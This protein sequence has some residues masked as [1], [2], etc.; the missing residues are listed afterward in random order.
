M[1]HRTAGLPPATGLAHVVRE[2]RYHEFSRQGLGLLLV[3]VF[4]L[5]A[6]PTPALVYAGLAFVVI[7]T[8]WRLYAAGCII[9]NAE[10]AAEGE[11][12]ARFRREAIAASKLDHPNLIEVNDMGRA[13]EVV[14][15]GEKCFFLRYLAGDALAARQCCGTV[16]VLLR[17]LDRA[18]LN[19]IR[20]RVRP[21]LA[22]AS[23][24]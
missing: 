23:Q 12:V 20:Q 19:A 18:D 13:D 17:R 11:A 15:W 3:V 10:L 2:L 6:R 7:G 14:S 9:K 5:F 22:H 16:C 8:V 24:G 1:G 4:A 21:F